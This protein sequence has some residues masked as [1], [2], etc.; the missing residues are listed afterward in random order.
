MIIVASSNPA[1]HIHE[2]WKITSRI[3]GFGH[4]SGRRRPEP[5]QTLL[6]HQSLTIL[7]CAS[8]LFRSTFFFVLLFDGRITRLDDCG[9][10]LEKYEEDPDARIYQV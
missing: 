5:A 4:W 9:P 8:L 7:E 2:R 6:F 3:P 10:G 1:N